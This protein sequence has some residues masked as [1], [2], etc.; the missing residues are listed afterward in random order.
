MITK[1]T[2]NGIGMTSLRTRQRLVKR[3]QEQGITKP[4]VL[5]VM[6]RTPRH[7]FVEEALAS[8]AYD[9]TAL[10]IGYS[11]TISQPYVVARM[12][13]V[14]L[15]GDAPEKVLEVGTGSGYQAYVLSQLVKDVYTVERIAGLVIQARNRF[16]ALDARN[17]RVKHSDGT[18]GWSENGPYDAIIV[19]AA[20]RQIPPSLF[21]QLRVG[22]KLIAPCG[23]QGVQQLMLYLRTEQDIEAIPLDT[24]SF[25]PMLGGVVS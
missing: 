24:V 11:Q 8:R 9:D 20:S 19:T 3:L 7:L 12:T 18:W 14:L 16:R 10:P 13:E 5:E 25:V 4:A 21:D 6:E 22:G 15:E 1:Q 17:I 23:E 2:V